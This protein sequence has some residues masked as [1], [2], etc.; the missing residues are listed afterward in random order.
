MCCV[1]TNE[2]DIVVSISLIPGNESIP[3]SYNVYFPVTGILPMVGE[4]YKPFSANIVN[5]ALS[6]VDV[7]V[8]TGDSGN[9]GGGAIVGV[10]L[11][12]GEACK[13]TEGRGY[14]GCGGNGRVEKRKAIRDN[15]L[16]Y[17]LDKNVQFG[18]VVGKT[19]NRGKYNFENLKG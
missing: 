1:I 15:N 9:I 18:I 3:S 4:V 12:S 19:T 10:F 5:E 2:K 14:M 6:L 7:Y 8:V 17:L 13:A 11:D 16:I